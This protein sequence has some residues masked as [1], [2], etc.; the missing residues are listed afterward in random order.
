MMMNQKAFNNNYSS[1]NAASMDKI[2]P[3]IDNISNHQ[4]SVDNNT[5]SNYLQNPRFKET[6][7]SHSNLSPI[8]P[9]SNQVETTYPFYQI[10]TQGKLRKTKL[11]KKKKF[12]TSNSSI[13]LGQI[14][15]KMIGIKMGKD[16]SI[17]KMET[18]LLHQT[19]Q[20]Q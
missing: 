10:G 14:P 1:L 11:K 13:D 18:D 16:Q 19:M 6:N 4:H 2:I 15:L 20:N 7:Q 9:E 5:N 12:K 3:N 17:S 8:L